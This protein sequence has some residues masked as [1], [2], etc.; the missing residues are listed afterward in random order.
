M[1]VFLRAFLSYGRGPL[2]RLYQN[3][4]GHI[5]FTQS[6]AMKYES[7]ATTLFFPAAKAQV[8][9]NGTTVGDTNHC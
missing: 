8:T 1:L 7:R 5:L 2:E 4:C 6:V 3:S 9:E